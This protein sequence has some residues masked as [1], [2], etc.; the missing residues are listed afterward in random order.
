MLCSVLD[1]VLV[2]LGAGSLMAWLYLVLLHGGFWRCDQRLG[3]APAPAAWPAVT[4]VVPA[5]DEAEVIAASVG[6]LLDQDYPGTFAIVLVDDHSADCTAEIARETAARHPRG[7]RLTVA[8]AGELPAGWVGKPWA[9]A[10][11][12]RAAGEPELLLLTDADVVHSPSNLRR[13]VSK[14]Q[15]EGL[16]LASLMVLLEQR[17]PWEKLLIPAFVYF[18]QQLYPFRRVNRPTARTAG[19]AGGCM[20]VRAR[21]LAA[22]GGVAA[23][24]GE[25]IDDC[26]LARLLKRRGRIWLGLTESERSVRPYGGLGGVWRMVARTAYTQLRRSPWLLAGTAAALAWIYLGPPLL[27]LGWPLH[28]VGAAAVLGGAA[29]LLMA[30]TFLPT[31]R[32]YRRS[33][34]WA[35]ALP[36]AGVLY[37]GMT[38]DSAWRHGRRRGGGWKGRTLANPPP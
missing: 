21:A 18:F 2:A 29:W 11:G 38:V 32:L 12:V 26:A 23:I 30:L 37:L 16:D 9:V 5:R 1:S 14:A 36:L 13:L 3:D 31:L 19:A 22:A 17:T 8:A 33:P 4:A 28:G 35:L 10:S 27:A 15:A 20:L 7:Q 24:R 34:A 6:S 25:L